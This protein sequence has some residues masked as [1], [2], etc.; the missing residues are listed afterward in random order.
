M[1]VLSEIV[2]KRRPVLPTSRTESS[3]LYTVCKWSIH[4]ETIPQNRL[5]VVLVSNGSVKDK[6]TP[7]VRN[8]VE[9]RVSK[10]V[11]EHLLDSKIVPHGKIRRRLIAHIWLPMICMDKNKLH[12]FLHLQN[13]TIPIN[14]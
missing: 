10:M 4:S 11:I 9:A 6:L 12:E 7:T 2:K 13:P 8:S 1:N 3:S 5:P 14:D